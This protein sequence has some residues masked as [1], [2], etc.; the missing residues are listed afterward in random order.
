MEEIAE[1]ADVARATLYNHF[2]SKGEVVLALASSI[3]EQWL[4]KG[5]ARLE[6]DRSPCAA[7]SEV[8]IGAAEWF[9]KH[10]DS[11]SAFFYA[12]REIMTQSTHES[13]PPT[14]I[15]TEWIVAAQKQGELTNEL[16]PEMVMLILDSVLRHHM[17]QR[18]RGKTKGK[19]AASVRKHL[20]IA[21]QRLQ[22]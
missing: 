12:M 20:D 6:K 21:M 1:K 5:A 8:L 4:R 14:L 15:P 7:I 19:A 16:P 18:V 9:D 10:P 2:P 13:P 17:I 11:A 22:P 3:A